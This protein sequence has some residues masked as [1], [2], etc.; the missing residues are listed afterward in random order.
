MALAAAASAAGATAPKVPLGTFRTTI[1]DVDLKAGGVSDI[2]ENHGTY[3][4]RLL[5]EGHWKL[6][7]VAPNP[8]HDA[9]HV[10]TYTV[11]KNA[12][13]FTDTGFDVSFTARLAF[14]GRHL[15]FKILSADIPELRV[16]WGAHPWTKVRG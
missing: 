2:A 7:Q 12:V 15:R 16:I 1:T 14:D 9:D 3:T 13:R 6:H 11:R 10:G 5:P 4:M 8:L